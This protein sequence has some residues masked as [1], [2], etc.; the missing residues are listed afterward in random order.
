[1]LLIAVSGRFARWTASV[2]EG[3]RF[4]WT[5]FHGS[6]L[7]GVRRASAVVLGLIFIVVGIAA[8]LS[9]HG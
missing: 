5:P 3:N 7:V 4:W 6:T 2:E 1:V 8:A 9:S